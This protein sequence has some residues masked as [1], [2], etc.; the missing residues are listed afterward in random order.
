LKNAVHKYPKKLKIIKSIKYKTARI[1]KSKKIFKINKK[2][3]FQKKNKNKNDAIYHPRIFFHKTARPNVVAAP[4]TNNML[5][6]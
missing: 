1:Q 5:Q 4:Q 3:P 6:T 2:F